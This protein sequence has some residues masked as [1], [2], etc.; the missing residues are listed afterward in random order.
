MSNSSSF[1]ACV[2]YFSIQDCGA[3]QQSVYIQW[4]QVWVSL[5]G[6]AFLVLLLALIHRYLFVEERFNTLKLIL[7]QL[8]FAIPL[9]VDPP[10]AG[11]SCS[12]PPSSIGS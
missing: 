4:A 2:P 1:G 6:F 12:G 3:S 10:R 8:L 9:C 5:D 11:W 7:C